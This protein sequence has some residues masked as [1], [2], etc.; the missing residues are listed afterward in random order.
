MLEFLSSQGG[1]G[2][3]PG[4]PGG[5]SSWPPPGGVGSSGRPGS[6][7]PMIPPPPALTGLGQSAPWRTSS[8]PEAPGSPRSLSDHPS[9]YRPKGGVPTPFGP[10]CRFP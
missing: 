6:D 1:P 9:G 2:S 8:S 5:S 4:A 10:L 7:G 3:R